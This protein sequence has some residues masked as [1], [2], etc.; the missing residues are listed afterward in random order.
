[1]RLLRRTG[2]AVFASIALL[3]VMSGGSRGSQADAL[4]V[5]ATSGHGTV[6]FLITDDGNLRITQLQRRDAPGQ[7]PVVGDFAGDTTLIGGL[8]DILWYTPGPGGDVLWRTNGNGAWTEIPISIDGDYVPIVGQFNGGTQTDH[9]DDVFWYAAGGAP[10]AI[11]NFRDNGTIVKT[12][13]EVN[14]SYVPIKGAFSNDRATDIVWYGPGGGTDSWWDFN[15]NGT[16]TK[17]PLTINGSYIPRVG[18]FCGSPNGDASQDI[19]WYAP[20][21]GR[22]SVWDWNDD[23]GIQK[24][25]FHVDGT[26]TPITGSFSNDEFDD[27][28]WYSPGRG[29]DIMW[30]INSATLAHTQR[31]LAIDGTYTPIT[32]TLFWDGS[33]RTDILWFGPGSAFDQIW[34]F[35]QSGS[36]TSRPITVSGN[37]TPVLAGL[38]I[39]IYGAGGVGFPI[40]TGDVIDRH[41]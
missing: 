4:P 37:R 17:K 13:V 22:D 20:G 3:S 11:W 34:D 32:G 9:K 39:F 23:G 33:D 30:D 1:M 25:S 5:R 16:I 38:A 18:R 19:L 41:T 36:Y 31:T 14:G 2:T 27:I 24:R 7:I 8:D 40:S 28:L 21:T 10:D 26:Y 12:P 15:A 35:A 6:D 29:Q